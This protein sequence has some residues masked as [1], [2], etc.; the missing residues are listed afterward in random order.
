MGVKGCEK[1]NNKY[2]YDFVLV[3]KR[4]ATARRLAGMTQE[5][6]ARR[7]GVGVNH[8]SEIERGVGGIAIGTLMEL[9]KILNVSADYILFG[10]DISSSPLSVRIQKILPHQKMYLEE[11]INTFI[12][13]CLDEQCFLKQAD[14]NTDK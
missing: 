4:I 14:G 3:G 12:N 2:K 8:L 11:L 1:M 6:V 13:C 5:Q 7:L 10:E 9:V